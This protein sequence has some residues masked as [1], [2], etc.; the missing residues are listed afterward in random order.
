MDKI[1][2]QDLPDT[3]TP[4]DA[5]NMNLL[6]TNVETAINGK[7]VDSL[8]GSSTT[9]APSVHAVNQ[10]LATKLDFETTANNN[11]IPSDS[12]YLDASGMKYREETLNV[13]LNKV[14][15]EIANV[16]TSSGTT[17]TTTFNAGKYN[18]RGFLITNSKGGVDTTGS[19]SLWF[20]TGNAKIFAIANPAN[21]TLTSSINTTTGDITL[22]LTGGQS[23]S[24]LIVTVL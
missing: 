3:T 14:S 6:Q 12:K 22:T 15:Y 2:F 8:T 9:E 18:V 1:N 24:N 16:G 20:M 13:Y 11:Y 10:I 4:I 21:A 19:Y 5:T 23:Y 17:A 7:V